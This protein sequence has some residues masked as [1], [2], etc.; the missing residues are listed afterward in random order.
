MLFYATVERASR[1]NEYGISEVTTP[2]F[3]LPD[4]LL[5]C[6]FSKHLMGNRLKTDF[7]LT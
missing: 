4:G 6:E 2:Y 7:S 1:K 3:P 5:L